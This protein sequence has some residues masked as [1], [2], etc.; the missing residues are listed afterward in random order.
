MKHSKDRYDQLTNKICLTKNE[1]GTK[2]DQETTTPLQ[3]PPSVVHLASNI[4]P[5]YFPTLQSSC[6]NAQYSLHK[7]PDKGYKRIALR[8]SL[9]RFRL[10]YTLH[11]NESNTIHTAHINQSTPVSN[12]TTLSLFRK[13]NTSIIASTITIVESAFSDTFWWP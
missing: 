4:N 1:Q 8:E 10:P 9:S 3:I 7:L 13:T 12:N 6:K 2:R 11:R 5:S